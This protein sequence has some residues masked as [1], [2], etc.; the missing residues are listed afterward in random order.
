MRKTRIVAACAAMLPAILSGTAMAQD[1]RETI[2]VQGTYSVPCPEVVWCPGGKCGI[3]IARADGE[4]EIIYSSEEEMGG[5][6][7]RL[8]MAGEPV[9]LQNV[10]GRVIVFEWDDSGQV[11]NP[12]SDL[13]IKNILYVIMPPANAG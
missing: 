1:A 7:R 3:G 12:G 2:C 5:T 6:H 9:S 8:V 4:V 10:I 11:E 13:A